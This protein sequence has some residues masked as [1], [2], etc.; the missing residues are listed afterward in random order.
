MDDRIV[1]FL[2]QMH[3]LSLSVIFQNCPYAASCFYAFDS[4]KFLLIVAG[5]LDSVHTKAGLDSEVAGTIALDT[6]IVG[7]I[8]GVQFK[9]R[10]VKADKESEKIYFKRFAYAALMKPEIFAIELKFVK[11]TCNTLGFGKKLIWT[12]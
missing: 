2:S 5:S 12:R 7:K 8:K 1:K 3:L 4:E 10:M 9:G 11:F 6:K